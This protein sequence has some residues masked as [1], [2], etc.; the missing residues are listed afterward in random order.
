MFH[1]RVPWT[2]I[3][4][5]RKQQEIINRQSATKTGFEN[6]AQLIQ[7]ANSMDCSCTSE[8]SGMM[9][10]QMPS[11]MFPGHFPS[12]LPPITGGGNGAGFFP[13]QRGLPI[14]SFNGGSTQPMITMP[15][16]RKF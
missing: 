6:F 7:L 1:Q 14:A 15:Y 10:G 12:G 5:V 8:P 3:E 11:G 2:S 9:A 4:Q 16:T 13:I